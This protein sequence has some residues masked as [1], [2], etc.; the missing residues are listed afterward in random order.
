MPMTEVNKSTLQKLD[1]EAKRARETLQL[2]TKSSGVTIVQTNY[3]SRAA[4]Y[5]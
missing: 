4:H 5:S 3:P 2:A 1:E